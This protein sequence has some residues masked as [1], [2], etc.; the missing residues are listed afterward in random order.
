[1]NKVA[2]V[3]CFPLDDLQTFE[4]CAERWANTRRRFDPGFPHDLH[5]AFCNGEMKQAQT[6][7]FSGIP[8]TAHPVKTSGW[9]IGTYQVMARRVRSY[10]LVVF[11][12]AR[13][14]FWKDGWLKRLMEARASAYDPN[15]VYGLSA[16]YEWCYLGNPPT[17]KAPTPHIRTACFSTNPNTFDRYPYRIESREH[18]FR[19]ESGMWNMCQWYEDMGYPVWMVTWDGMYK[20]P[21]WRTPPNIFRRGD[22][23]A[24]LVCDRHTDIYKNADA[25]ERERLEKAANGET[26][27]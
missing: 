27:S 2:L 19:F 17:F 1:M 24:M 23:S 13:V 7:I 26:F 8:F 16:S 5:V 14:H 25:K 21:E 10:D 18:G 4:I 9:D 3:Y 15:A 20:K 11:M 6:D 12:N 22:Q